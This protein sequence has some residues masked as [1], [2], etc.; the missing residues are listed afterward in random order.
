[1]NIG[2]GIL[3]DL[4]FAYSHG[5]SGLNFVTPDCEIADTGAHDLNVTYVNGNISGPAPQNLTAALGGN[6]WFDANNNGI[7]DSDE[8]GVRWVTVNLYSCSGA[9]Y[10]WLLTDSLGNYQFDSL[11]P[12]SY[13]VQF[14]LID[15]N[16]AY[17]FTTQNSGTDSTI[18]SHVYQVNDSTGRT[19]C[20]LL[21]G[22]EVYST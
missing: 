4:N 10:K 9:W 16:K 22:R 5:N 13:Y 8:K 2:N 20:V 18:N 3:M 15:N 14:M 6:V 12:G 21:F 7:K 19:D 17:K 1:M 11:N